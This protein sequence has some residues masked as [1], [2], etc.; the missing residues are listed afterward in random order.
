MKLIERDYEIFREIERWRF[1]LGRHIRVLTGFAGQRACDRR[2]RA[3]LEAGYIKREKIMYGVPS[4]YRLTHKG[5]L[6]IGANKRQDKVRADNIAHDIAVIDVAIYLHEHLSIAFD[7]IITEKQLHTRDGFSI[8]LHQP[9]FIFTRENKAYCVEVELTLKSK[10]RL[11][12][13]LKNNFMNYDIQVWII[14]GT[15]TVLADT[16]K[17]KRTQ[18]DNIEIIDVKEVKKYVSENY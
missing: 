10:E 4:L 6:L 12:K 16:L 2:L 11:E 13:N 17:S 15:G 3:L 1:C 9:D 14:E 18:Y 8:R 7:D 5:K